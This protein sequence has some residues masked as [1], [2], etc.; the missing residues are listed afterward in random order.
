MQTILRTAVA[1]LSFAIV[2]LPLAC[3]TS[4]SDLRGIVQQGRMVIE[5]D[6]QQI[7]VQ[8]N[9]MDIYLVDPEY[10]D[11]YPEQFHIHGEEIELVGSF[12]M[13]LH[14]GYGEDL[15]LM[16]GHRV[17]IAPHAQINWDEFNSAVNI[18]ALG[19]NVRSGSLVVDRV[20]GQNPEGAGKVIEG[21]LTLELDDR[22]TARGAFTLLAVTW[23]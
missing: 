15:E 1:C 22:R 23:G 7:P 5:L 20:L 6:G 14:V 9:G 12:P 17:T 11:Q 21:T 16:V 13:N 2:L 4:S 19:G 10:E 3:G 18:P 8:V